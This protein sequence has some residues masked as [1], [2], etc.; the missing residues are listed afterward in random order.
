MNPKPFFIAW[1]IIFSVSTSLCQTAPEKHLSQAE[2]QLLDKIARLTPGV[3]E[4][5]VRAEFPELG[6]KNKPTAGHDGSLVCEQKFTLTGLE[7]SAYFYF[8]DD[9]FKQA[10]FHASAPSKNYGKETVRA[11]PKHE[12][13]DKGLQIA[14]HYQKRHGQVAELYVPNLDCP[15][16][17]PF[18]LLRIWQIENKALSIEFFKVSSNSSL[19]IT[20][21]DWMEWQQ[22]QKETYREQWPFTPPSKKAP[23]EVSDPNP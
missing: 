1:I 12:M 4:K 22:E 19:T 17:N 2:I 15:A 8:A 20:L 6:E 16:G 21:S 7:W 14:S 3:S 18:G 9:V 11:V 23:D 5:E 10:V 13:R